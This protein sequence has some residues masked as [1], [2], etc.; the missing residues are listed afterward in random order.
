MGD[1][2]YI[3]HTE[4]CD[5]CKSKG[6]QV[7]ALYD[8][9]TVHG[10]WAYMCEEHFGAM[11]VGLGTGRGQRLIVGEKPSSEQRSSSQGITEVDD[12]DE[13][14]ET[15]ASEAN[16]EPQVNFVGNEDSTPVEEPEEGKSDGSEGLIPTGSMNA[17]SADSTPTQRRTQ[18]RR[19]LRAERRKQALAQLMAEGDSMRHTASKNA[20]EQLTQVSN[21]ESDEEQG[22]YVMKMDWGN[23]FR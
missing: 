10:P 6:L 21:R 1:T 12:E 18:Q 11:G 3:S 8:G 17:P 20:E 9:K 23:L 15:I 19:R 16:N 14:D 5:L 4:Y 22:T 2:A 13:T 7:E